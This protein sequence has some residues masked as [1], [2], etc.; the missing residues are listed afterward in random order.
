[1]NWLDSPVVDDSMYCLSAGQ[2]MESNHSHADKL[3]NGH[4]REHDP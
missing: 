1:M 2:R 4:M 3:P